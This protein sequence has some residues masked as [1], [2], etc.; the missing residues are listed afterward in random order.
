MELM[1]SRLICITGGEGANENGIEALP[2][3]LHY[4]GRALENGI[5]AHPPRFFYGGGG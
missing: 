4:G 1:N 5:E 2:P 3:R